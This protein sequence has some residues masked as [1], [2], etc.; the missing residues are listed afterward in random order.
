MK[1]VFMGTP[2]FA[3][4]CLQA[5]LD[6]PYEV[7][8]V[9]TQPDKP[10]GRGYQ[11]TPPPVKELAVSKGIPVSQPTTLR[12][13]TALEQ[14]KI[15]KP[16]LIVVVAYGKFLPK[17][18]LELPR[19]GCINVHASLLPKYRGAGPIQW[20]IL[21]GETV[22][23]VTTMYMAEGMDTGAMLERASLEIGPDETADELHDR[24]SVLGAK[25]LLST[26]DKAEKGT[27]QPEKQDDS[28]ASYA[29]MLTKDLSHID[30]SQP[31]QKIHN[32]IRGLSSWPAAYTS[33][34]GK[35][36]KVYKSCMR[37]GSGEPGLLMDPKR[38]IVACGEG[39]IEL[40]EVQ[41]EGSRKMSGEEFLRGKKPAEKEFLG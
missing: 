24:L 36:L 14:L 22:T 10:K 9:F 6:H 26:V 7:V 39:A 31:A 27:L 3:V 34:Q 28:L 15:W 4:P 20:A 23:G 8:G 11:L 40:V 41:Y 13:G 16:D 30:F 21:N 5:L 32:Q 35:R 29:P 37:D 19:L 12:D 17:E 2:D 38:M 33:Y 25:L 1:I 18:I